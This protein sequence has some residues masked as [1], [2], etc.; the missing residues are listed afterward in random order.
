[1]PLAERNGLTRR[2]KQAR[3]VDGWSAAALL[4][5]FCARPRRALR[6]RAA[7]GPLSGEEDGGGEADEER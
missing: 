3:S 4:E 5:A 6:V 2:D 1:V 7:V